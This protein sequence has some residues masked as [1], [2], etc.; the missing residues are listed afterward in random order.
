MADRRAHAAAA[1]GKGAD[2]DLLRQHVWGVWGR[3][4]ACHHDSYTCHMFPGATGWPT[5]RVNTTDHNFFGAV[6]KEMLFT[7]PYKKASVMKNFYLHTFDTT[8]WS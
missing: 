6:G 3:G 4:D 8:F 5:Q 7:H 1:T 2:Q